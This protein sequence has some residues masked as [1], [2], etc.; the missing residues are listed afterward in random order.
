MNTSSEKLCKPL[1]T[2]IRNL[3]YILFGGFHFIGGRPPSIM[4]RGAAGSGKSL[5]CSTIAANAFS[6][7]RSVAYFVLEQLAEDVRALLKQFEFGRGIEP[8]IDSKFTKMT[9]NHGEATRFVICQYL[10][11]AEAAKQ[12]SGKVAALAFHEFLEAKIDQI[13]EGRPGLVIIDTLADAVREYAGEDDPEMQFDARRTFVL[14]LTQLGRRN[15][16]PVIMALETTDEIEWRDYVVDA[17]IRLERP[18]VEYFDKV[19]YHF[20]E[21][22]KVRNQPMLSGYHRVQ[23]VPEIGIC[24]YP[25]ATQAVR[26]MLREGAPARKSTGVFCRFPDMEKL[27]AHRWGDGVSIEPSMSPGAATLLYGEDRTRK[28]AIASGFLAGGLEDNNA[29]GLYLTAGA[30]E[31]AVAQMLTGYWKHLIPDHMMDFRESYLRRTTIVSVDLFEDDL[32]SVLKRLLPILEFDNVLLNRVIVDDLGALSIGGPLVSMLRALFA[33]KG[34][35]SLFVHTT[36]AGEGSIH[37]DQFENVIG[38]RHLLFPDQI[39]TKIAYTVEKLKGI[40]PIAKSWELVVDRRTGRLEFQDTFQSYMEGPDRRVSMLPLE[41]MLCE[42]FDYC[43]EVIRNLV[44]AVFGAPI[45]RKSRQRGDGDVEFP[46]ITVFGRHDADLVF[47]GIFDSPKH[48]VLNKTKV[49]CFDDPWAD[50]LIR[51]GKLERIDDLIPPPMRS[52][53]NGKCLQRVHIARKAI[54][55]SDTLYGLPQHIDIGFYIVHKEVVKGVIE[56]RGEPVGKALGTVSLEDLHSA[57]LSVIA[58]SQSK[59]REVAKDAL[60]KGGAIPL[61]DFSANEIEESFLAFFL[62]LLYPFLDFGSDTFGFEKEVVQST[63]CRIWHILESLDS[64]P[65]T[66]LDFSKEGN[67]S[68]DNSGEHDRTPPVTQQFALIQRHWYVSYRRLIARHAHIERDYEIISAP[69]LAGRQA[70]YLRGDWFLGV[71]KGSSNRRRGAWAIRSLTTP[72]FNNRLYESGLGLAARMDVSMDRVATHK[73]LP[74]HSNGWSRSEFR[75]YRIVRP[76]LLTA[77]SGIYRDF[78]PTDEEKRGFVRASAA[79]CDSLPSLRETVRII[80]SELCN[81][82]EECARTEPWK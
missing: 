68:S 41:I 73:L 20:L 59:W 49:F 34:I 57:V 76:L 77:L 5:L 69:K 3:D 4:V 63:L 27:L 75:R 37:R 62:E 82:L 58:S 53:F 48:S 47:E 72:G 22:R 18:N 71:L 52:K 8:E 25:D 19:P 11:S 36:K 2:G 38:T 56:K 14:G 64:L 1:S 13:F 29:N 81:G 32:M 78:R 31:G 74:F 55:D 15:N 16:A 39:T 24:V 44:S 67:F 17:V 21:V 61:F 65:S 28:N 60:Q 43:E 50:D 40:A 23:I 30:S 9:S 42:P 79:T 54:D 12:S 66:R 6:S 46:S 10:A 35:L 45:Q 33:A 7:G 70:N 26:R 80:V 51:S